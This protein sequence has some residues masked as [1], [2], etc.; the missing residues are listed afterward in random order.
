MD[1]VDNSD[2]LAIPVSQSVVGSCQTR[3]EI[4]PSQREEKIVNPVALK[5]MKKS[6][7]YPF[8]AL[9]AFQFE[10]CHGRTWVGLVDPSIYAS[11]L[12][13]P[14]KARFKVENDPFVFPAT[15]ATSAP[16]P[17][18]IVED[19]LNVT[20]NTTETIGPSDLGDVEFC[21]SN[22][23]LYRIR[24]YDSWGDGWDGTSMK[25]R[26]ILL[27]GGESNHVSNETWTNDVHI[28][29]RT[30]ALRNVVPSLIFEGSLPRGREG[31]SFTCL[32]PANCYEVTVDGGHWTEEIKWD[33]ISDPLDGENQLDRTETVVALKGRAPEKC[34]FSIPNVNGSR[35]CP[36]L[37][38]TKDKKTKEVLPS[39]A[40]S[41]DIET[42]DEEL[43]GHHTTY[44]SSLYSDEPSLVPVSIPLE[45]IS[46]V[47]SGAPSDYPSIVPSAL[48]GEDEMALPLGEILPVPESIS[49]SPT[50]ESSSMFPTIPED[51][52]PLRGSFPKSITNSPTPDTSSMFPTFSESSEFPTMALTDLEL[53]ELEWSLRPVAPSAAT[54]SRP[55][56]TESSS[57]PSDEPSLVPSS[58]RPL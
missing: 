16:F 23:Y 2:A 34:Q 52:V 53:Q 56:R 49:I 51:D 3:F 20:T 29:T 11:A 38:Q 14:N 13:D 30:V 39:I 28:Y 26:E 6:S 17:P 22:E 32:N 7:I 37:C 5:N 25:I 1:V 35:R 31:H 58:Y 46:Q 54:G 33:I 45:D 36:T 10:R 43:L 47:S 9:S 27:S 44:P 55:S 24:M 21:R 12:Q 15:T 19:W 4:R 18:V 40:P 42:T 8:V 57:V 41:L 50:A 48:S